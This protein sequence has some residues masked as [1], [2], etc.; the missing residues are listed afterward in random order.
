M[1]I[2]ALHVDDDED[3]GFLVQMGLEMSGDYEVRWVDSG[4]EAL[5]VVEE[6]VPNL[7]ILDVMMPEMD[8]PTTLKMLRKK[9]RMADVPVVFLTAKGEREFDYL[10]SIGAQGAINKPFNPTALAEQ[11]KAYI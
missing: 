8:G 5:D 7:I 1:A 10:R 6:W 2:K 4:K 9:A 11:L 3:I